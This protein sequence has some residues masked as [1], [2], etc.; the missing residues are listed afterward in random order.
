VSARGGQCQS[1]RGTTEPLGA[2]VAY[3]RTG[4]RNGVRVCVRVGEK[5]QV[6]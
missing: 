1:I 4:D 3:E 5:T 2:R 6:K